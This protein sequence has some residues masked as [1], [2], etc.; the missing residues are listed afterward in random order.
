MTIKCI[1]FPA[2]SV[3]NLRRSLKSL[4]LLLK[5]LFSEGRIILRGRS[6]VSFRISLT[7]RGTQVD[8]A[9]TGVLIGWT[10]S[11]SASSWHEGNFRWHDKQ[12]VM[13]DRVRVGSRCLGAYN[14]CI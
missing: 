6:V 11:H 12:W 9:R 10:S 14:R 5:L 3:F 13:D 8:Q 1:I 4:S 7:F 2:T